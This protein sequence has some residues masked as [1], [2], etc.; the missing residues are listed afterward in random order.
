MIKA[1]G[2]GIAMSNA[3]NSAKQAADIIAPSN[4]ECGVAWAVEK[5]VL[6]PLNS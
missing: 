6:E 3:R 2:I 5:Y 1:A 4:D